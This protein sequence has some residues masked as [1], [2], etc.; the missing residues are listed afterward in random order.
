MPDKV[1]IMLLAVQCP[2]LPNKVGEVGGG[3]GKNLI[4]TQDGWEMCFSYKVPKG[5]LICKP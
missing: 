2:F 1:I 4:I 5:L 3:G